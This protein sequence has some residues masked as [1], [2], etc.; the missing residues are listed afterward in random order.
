[1][2]FFEAAATYGSANVLDGM[3]Q[4][5]SIPIEFA[6]DLSWRIWRAFRDYKNGMRY[7]G[8]AAPSNVDHWIRISK[9]F[10]RYKST[11]ELEDFGS[12]DNSS[13]TDI[14]LSV[15]DR[16]MWK[17]CQH[18]LHLGYDINYR[19][20]KMET[21]LIVT[22]RSTWPSSAAWLQTL[23][24]N[25]A[26]V[27]LLDRKGRSPLHKALQH[28]E[29]IYFEN[30]YTSRGE[31]YFPGAKREYCFLVEEKL[32]SLLKAGCSPRVVDNFGRSPGSYSR[33]S[34]L[35]STWVRALEATGNVDAIDDEVSG[36]EPRATLNIVPRLQ[37]SACLPP[38]RSKGLDL[39]LTLIHPTNIM[40]FPNLHAVNVRMRGYCSVIRCTKR[41]TCHHALYAFATL[42]PRSAKSMRLQLQVK[43]MN[44]V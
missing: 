3:L 44:L 19:N 31:G 41:T 20:S 33:Y 24:E 35:H 15:V 22:A 16:E 40:P 39:T 34:Y 37:V 43:T 6:A 18:F 17:V 5:L 2:L 9:S 12:M 30:S 1:M 23:I 25:G 32:I 42:H 7:G 29:C 4:D 26:N 38:H 14:N 13:F 36:L 28:K 27:F 10:H 21:P 11:T 8:I